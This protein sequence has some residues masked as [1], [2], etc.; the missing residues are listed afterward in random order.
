MHEQA[1]L[2]EAVADNDIKRFAA[3]EPVDLTEQLLAQ[4]VQRVIRKIEVHGFLGAA[5][6]MPRLG[7]ARMYALVI[8]SAPRNGCDD[9]LGQSSS[10]ESFMVVG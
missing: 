4:T 3:Q 9:L 6:R 1:Y 7:F 10:C 2:L 8:H 5:G